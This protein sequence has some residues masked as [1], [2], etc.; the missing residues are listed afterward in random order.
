MKVNYENIYEHIGYLFYALA[1]GKGKLSSAELV[2][3]T[4]MIEKTWK[5]ITNGDPVLHMH[6]VDCIHA[7]VRYAIDNLMRPDHALTS[8]CDYFRIYSLPFSK[9]LKEKIIGSAVLILKEFS[10]NRQNE[11]VE[12]DLEELM[13]LKPITV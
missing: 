2:R 12:T 6:L 11:H 1:S 3:L 8:F 5:P 10:G 9:T 4:D 13:G 7:G